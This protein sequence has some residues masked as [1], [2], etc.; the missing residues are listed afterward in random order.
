MIT[1]G[2]LRI[3]WWWKEWWASSRPLL[4]R[5]RYPHDYFNDEEQGKV[6]FTYI[7]VMYWSYNLGPLE[8]RWWT[9]A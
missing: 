3:L 9:K 7:D 8:F 4:C 5:F 1:L 2:R 6:D